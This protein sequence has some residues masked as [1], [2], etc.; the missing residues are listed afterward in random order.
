MRVLV[1]F[2]AFLFPLV[3]AAQFSATQ[4]QST[5]PQLVTFAGSDANLQALVAGLGAGQPVTLVTQAGGGVLQIVTFTPPG[6]LSA[7][8][9]A[10]ALEQAR[11][12]LISRGIGQPSA[13]QIAVA[14][15]GGSLVTS[16]GP[17][18]VPGVLT[19]SI[20]ANA[21]Q[22]RNELA[23]AGAGGTGGSVFGGSAAN[24]QNLQN[25]LQRGTAITLNG[26]AANG[27]A[28]TV[29]FTA[30]GG[31]MTA[32]EANQALQLAANTLALQGILS[33]TPEQIRAALVG[34]TVT[35]SGGNLVA[36]Q[37][38][39]QGR[40]R[41]TSDSGV[42]ASNSGVGTSNS[43]AITSPF[44][45]TPAPAISSPPNVAAPITGTGGAPVPGGPRFG[46]AR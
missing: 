43:T 42:G 1:T 16:A 4:I 40:V 32:F 3:A 45:N 30:P 31:P 36:L 38:V 6:A 28:R 11:T 22:V 33:P 20:P 25:G 13:Q 34:G 17:L 8:D 10:R 9:T 46:A 12:S 41:N 37:G 2:L 35:A 14:L 29:T 27:A 24:L 21:V 39:L 26:T 5:S 23:T 19:G 15:M 7:A 18:Q 44:V